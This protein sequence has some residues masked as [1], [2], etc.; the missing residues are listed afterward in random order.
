MSILE[1]EKI[2]PRKIVPVAAMISA[3]KSKLL[4][5]LYNIKFL[6]CKEGIGTKFVNL[7]RYNPDI[8]VPCFYH[9]KIEKEGEN[10]IFYKDLSQEIYKG[11]ESIIEA[12]KKINKELYSKNDFN[13]EDIFYMTEINNI[14]FIKDK[15]YLLKHDLC[16]IPGLSEY[17]KTR[18]EDDRKQKEQKEEKKENKEEVC[19]A[20]SL[21]TI[22]KKGEE[23]G[24]DFEIGK[25]ILTPQL[26]VEDNDEQ[27][28]K[29][30]NKDGKKDEDDIYYRTS[31]DE[32]NN[33]YL[34]EIFKIIKNYIEGGIIIMSVE[35]YY[36][37]ENFELIA[38]LYRV[39]QKN[40]IK[41]LVVFNKLDLSKNPKEDIEKFK[42]LIIKHF[43]KC[44]TFNI[45]L[46]TF[47][48]LSVNQLQN[49]LLMNQS[50]KYLLRYHFYNYVFIINKEKAT[51]GNEINKT[52]IEHL[53][54]IIKI[55]KNINRE[56]IEKKVEEINK[57]SNINEIN[58][59]IISIINELKEE[60]KG[61]LDIKLGITDKDFEDKDDE[62][63]FDFEVNDSNDN[64]KNDNINEM[65][66]AD[67]IKLF[68]SFHKNNIFMPSFS[69][70]TTNLLDYFKNENFES[71]AKQEIKKEEIN[72][73]SINRQIMKNLRRLNKKLDQSKI[74][75]LK[76]KS[77]INEI[78]QTIEFLKIYDVIFIPFLGIS[79]SGKTTIIN[80]MLGDD[81]LP[82]DLK[83]CTK[84]GIII[85]YY[86]GEMNIKKA[87][88]IKDVL[89]NKDY[90]Y[91]EAEKYV[92]GKGKKQVTEILKGLNYDFTDKE[93]DSFYYLQTK[94]NIFDELGFDSSL[95]K[96]IFLIDF[97]GF[98]T[99]NN[100][101]NEI[102]K[103]VMSISNSFIFTIKDGVIKDNNNQN[104]LSSLFNEAK[105][106]KQSLSSLF[107]KSCIFISN[108]FGSHSISQNDL[109]K[110]KEELNYLSDAI[111]KD[112]INFCFYNAQY[113]SNY[114][115]NKNYFFN[116]K[117]T[118]EFEYKNY[119][120]FQRNI[121]KDPEKIKGKNYKNF[122]EYIVKALGEKIKVAELGNMKKS[123][124]IDKNVEGEIRQVMANFGNRKII[125]M[126][127]TLKN[128]N[129]FSKI[130]SFGQEK[131]QQFKLLKESNY[132]EFK[133]VFNSQIIYVN[134]YIQKNVGQ[135]IDKVLNTLD[136][137]F[138]IDFSV[139]KENITE[140]NDF[141]KKMREIKS[142][143]NK[144]FIE[145]QNIL[146]L[147]IN[148][149]KET[150]IK[151]LSN[152]K[153]NINQFLKDKKFKKIINEINKEI[154]NNIKD[155]N[156]KII[157]VINSIDSKLSKI[158]LDAGI[159]IKEFSEGKTFLEKIDTFRNYFSSKVGDKVENLD[160]EILQELLSS[161][162]NLSSIYEKKGFKEWIFSAFSKEHYLI[163]IIELLVLSLLKKMEYILDL[164]IGYLKNYI[165]DL[166]HSIEK[167]ILLS[168]TTFTSEQLKYWEEIK[169]LYK[170]IKSKIIPLKDKLKNQKQ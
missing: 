86:E 39:I 10:Y 28:N 52:F 71:D 20:D 126:N 2:E 146:F 53:I 41:F 84:R 95:K 8:E 66:P 61:N 151:S 27:D 119:I 13:Y 17:Q 85:R 99:R 73:N 1:N 108:N 43:P 78:K 98:G 140:I 164:I 75:V 127:D 67:I 135:N 59:E 38:K 74:E 21:E 6:D 137:F 29:D 64:N 69:E 132:E 36:F 122:I 62:E 112:K 63:D 121:F 163:N 147:S 141:T 111:N 46:N 97:P 145:A 162:K 14:P 161:C 107:I 109:D 24:L 70:E 104:V 55:D 16:D 25:G 93:E 144:V 148:N 170:D 105:K 123:Q 7:L 129:S 19:L 58:N 9:L 42:G 31:I 49:E 81:I 142:R 48:P 80:G 68:Y 110:A 136:T 118:F 96:K 167:S 166:F 33:T 103:K 34:T 130:F 32:N 150:I 57:L 5:V 155:L 133:K 92:I 82:T 12:N 169:A 90:Y 47:I 157:E 138:S 143:I 159:I 54:N 113:Y 77:L 50:F 153:E 120:S 168:T 18:K 22:T 131:M 88:F 40:I 30:E 35:N 56:F 87:N 11:E 160:E 115:N 114:I 128:E 89:L 117:Q 101:E 102:Y 152:K 23:I 15:E 79:N 37:E 91:F 149:Y 3:G 154:E 156:Q 165:E 124:R 26:R 65:K 76:I 106:Q 139:K 83:E 72:E 134:E 51:N 125:E 158:S 44:K 4:N 60:Y 100:F 45:N 116:I 94:I